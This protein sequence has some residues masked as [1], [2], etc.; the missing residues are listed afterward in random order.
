MKICSWNVAGLRARLDNLVIWLKNANPDIVCLQEVKCEANKFPHQ[1][2]EKL[3]YKVLLNTQQQFNGVALLYK[4]NLRLNQI[5]NA[6]TILA[7]EARFIE[8]QFNIGDKTLNIAS[9]YAPNGNPKDSPSFTYKLKWLEELYK[10]SITKISENFILAGDFNVIPN[11]NDAKDITLWLQDALYDQRVR[12]FFKKLFYSGFYD[13]ALFDKYAAPYSFW[14]FRQNSWQK[15]NGIRIDFLLT[16]PYLT[17]KVIKH[18]N[19]RAMRN[20]EKPS[21]HTPVG[22]ELDID[23]CQSIF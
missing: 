16:T 20:W 1:I 15:D 13:T 10:Y 17:D 14:D 11:V 3:H 2:F 4:Q 8:A 5:I 6:T 22:L 9:L 19:Y 23:S 7:N 21:D 12:N 18:Y